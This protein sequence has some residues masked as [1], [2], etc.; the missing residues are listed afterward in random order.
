MLL[1]LGCEVRAGA[2][3][4][5]VPRP[6]YLIFSWRAQFFMAIG[7]KRGKGGGG[8]GMLLLAGYFCGLW[9][10]AFLSTGSGSSIELV[11]GK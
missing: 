8:D 1:P 11:L 7:G 4:E 3:A 10:Q 6:P 9:R 5:S 2:L